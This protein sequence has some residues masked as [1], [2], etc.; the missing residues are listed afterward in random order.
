MR[1]EALLRSHEVGGPHQ[2]A[3]PGQGTSRTAVHRLVNPCQPQVEDLHDGGG[4]SAAREEEIG[5]LD[6][7][8]N[9]AAFEGM[10]E[11]EGGLIDVARRLLDGQGARS[12][13]QPLEVDAVE[14][15]HRN[16]QGRRDGAG[17]VGVNDVGVRQ[18]AD[19]AAFPGKNGRAR[20][21]PCLEGARGERA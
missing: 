15:F 20:P 7:A 5:R 11:S 8:M 18:P 2:P 1:V 14:K 16:E 3:R 4:L 12:F 19:R 9:E 6:V 21:R 17:I 13:H 10:L